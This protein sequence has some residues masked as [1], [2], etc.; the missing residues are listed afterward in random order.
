MLRDAAGKSAFAQHVGHYADREEIGIVVAAG[1]LSHANVGLIHIFL[2]DQGDAGTKARIDLRH[3]RQIEFGWLPIGEGFFDFPFHL[4][5][6]DSPYAAQA[7]AW[8]VD[9][10]TR[11]DLQAFYERYY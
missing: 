2:L 3:R 9:A 10:V 6:A 8:T 1:D 5:G 11:A 4:L 7:E